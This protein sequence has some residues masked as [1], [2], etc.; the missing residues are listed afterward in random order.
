[1]K[2]DIL[3][4]EQG[5]LMH[6]SLRERSR[7]VPLVP[8]VLLVVLAMSVAADGSPASARGGAPTPD[9]HDTFTVD[10][11]SPHSLPTA[12][13]KMI[14]HKVI[15]GDTVQL[16][17]PG[18]DWYYVTR[19]VG[20]NAPESV[21]PIAPVECYGPEA[22]ARLKQLLPIGAV[23]YAERDVSDE[24]RFG[25]RLRHIWILDA[26]TQEAFLVSE[27]MVRGG[28]ADARLYRPDDL[29]DDE[30]EGA[31]KVAQREDV[32]LWGAC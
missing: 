2:S 17:Y 15:D 14:V 24:D 16:T 3:I 8:L 13:E 29:F 20:M 28:Y 18:D 21:K 23:V 12:A 30:L 27:I 25:R 31:E 1:M 6:M 7:I 22:S 32:G 11:A 4:R 10:G 26:D 5:F 19:I 9:A